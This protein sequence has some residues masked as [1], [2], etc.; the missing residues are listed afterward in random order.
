MLRFSFSVF[1]FIHFILSIIFELLFFF[2]PTLNS[3]LSGF[4]SPYYVHPQS[5]PSQR[6][7]R[8]S[9]PCSRER[10]AEGEDGRHSERRDG[11]DVRIED[12]GSGSCTPA[13]V[14]QLDDDG[15]VECGRRGAG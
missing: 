10:D 12:D 13:V 9:P 6:T 3:H 5:T 4:F 7:R 8:A 2:N 11:N 15:A 1:L 14:E